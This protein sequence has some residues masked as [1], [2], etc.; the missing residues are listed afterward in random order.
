MSQARACC[1]IRKM[2]AIRSQPMCSHYDEVLRYA[3]SVPMLIICVRVE[4][5]SPSPGL[6]LQRW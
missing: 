5:W 2:G 1:G 3:R 4:F 6:N